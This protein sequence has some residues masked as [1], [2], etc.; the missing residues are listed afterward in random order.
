MRARPGRHLGWGPGG[1]PAM[2]QSWA[3]CSS[4]ENTQDVHPG[5]T[6]LT[7]DVPEPRAEFGAHS[8]RAS[9]ALCPLF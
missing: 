2:S 9:A 7:P 8:P 3:V 5:P 1:E 4:G 6:R